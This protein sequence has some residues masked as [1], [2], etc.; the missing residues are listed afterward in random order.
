M[1]GRDWR[2]CRLAGG[3]PAKMG[4][5]REWLWLATTQGES[6]IIPR[7]KGKRIGSWLGSTEWWGTI[8]RIK[9][10]A[11]MEEN[12]GPNPTDPGGLDPL[13]H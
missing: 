9:C 6:S 12:W 7:T 13:G 3:P 5:P 11:N 4:P 1:G 2:V 10:C 8:K